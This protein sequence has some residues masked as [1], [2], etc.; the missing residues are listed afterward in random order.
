MKI[1]N[2]IGKKQ[3]KIILGD[4]LEKTFQIFRK[5]FIT[6]N[7]DLSVIN[8]NFNKSKPLL[9][10]FR[11]RIRLR[12]FCSNSWEIYDEI[13]KKKKKMSTMILF[14]SMKSLIQVEH[15][16]QPLKKKQKTEGYSVGIDV[17]ELIFFMSEESALGQAKKN[18]MMKVF[19]L[20]CV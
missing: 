10:N 16:K 3:R 5:N 4:S 8:E 12:S 1:G 17:I 2:Y 6:G 19:Q 15:V 7:K 20:M 9:L 11:A 18:M 14:F 13:S